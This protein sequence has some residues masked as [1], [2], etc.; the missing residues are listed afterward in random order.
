MAVPSKIAEMPVG[1][2]LRRSPGVTRWVSHVWTLAGI[3]LHAAPASWKP[4]RRSGEVEEFHAATLTL[5][6]HRKDTDSLVQNLCARTPSVWVALRGAGRPEPVKATA[7]PFEASFHEIDAE[8]RVE[9]VA[10]P[11]PMID[12]V[13]AFVAAHHEE[14]P[15]VKRR[16]DRLREG[17][18][19]DGIGDARIAQP[20]DVWRTPGSLRGRR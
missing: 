19:Q 11:A 20:A 3:L 2:L 15:F 13:A 7:S 16:R 6:L 17:E 9:R 8:D 1:I 12:W 5:Q 4:L 14:A 18:A 10:M